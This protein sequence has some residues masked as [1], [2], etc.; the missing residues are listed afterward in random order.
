MF[1]DH[2]PFHYTEDLLK[3]VEETYYAQDQEKSNLNQM[4]LG[5]NASKCPGAAA[6]VLSMLAALAVDHEVLKEGAA[7]DSDCGVGGA[8]IGGGAV[9]GGDAVVGGGGAVVGG[10]AV[11]GA[12]GDGAAVTGTTVNEHGTSTTP[13]YERMT[14]GYSV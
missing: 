3:A 4:T 1:H 10:G 7:S 11:G 8:A 9:V 14:D 12:V 5:G 2:L 13:V 6:R